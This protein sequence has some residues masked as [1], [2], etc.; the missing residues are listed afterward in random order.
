MEYSTREN[1]FFDGTIINENNFRRNASNGMS[2]DGGFTT[3]GAFNRL[4]DT[5]SH[6]GTN[7]DE[8]DD[9]N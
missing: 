6:N 9:D 3:N 2:S 4:Q 8:Y 7:E 1:E 5:V